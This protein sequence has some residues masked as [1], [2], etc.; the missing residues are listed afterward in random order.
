MASKK[1]KASTKASQQ[2]GSRRGTS[3]L[4]AVWSRRILAVGLGLGVL[5]VPSV[6]VFGLR[7][8]FGPPKALVL[9][10]GA[11]LALA[12]LALDTDATAS[13][14]S[15]LRRSR[16]AWAAAALVGIAV[17]STAT[18]LD[19]RLAFIGGYPDYRGLLSV[20]AYAALALGSI[21]FWERPKGP[22][23][24]GRYAVV[25]AAWVGVIAVLQRA[26]AFPA[27]RPGAF[28]VQWRVSSTLGNSSNLGVFLV[29]IAP[30]L[31]WVALKDPR[32][33]WRAA[34]SA[35]ATLAVISLAWTLSR[36]AW[37]GAIVSA[38]LCGALVVWQRGRFSPRQIGV[39]LVGLAVV[40]AL[41]VALTPTFASRAATLFDTRSTTASW[42][43]STWRS[44]ARMTAARPFLGFGPNTFRLAYPGFQSPGQIDG[45][46]G[47]QIVEAAHNL[48]FDTSTSFGVA[49]LLALLAVMGLACATVF[50]EVRRDGI[51]DGLTASIGIALAGGVV[52]LQ[53]HYLT[54]DT[55]PLVAV[56]LAGLVVADSR[57]TADESSLSSSAALAG[58]IAAGVL[59]GLYLV[60]AGLSAGL[61]AAD[62]NA[63]LAEQ[64]A[65]RGAAWNSVDGPLSRAEALAFWEPQIQRSR[66]TAA[67]TILIKRFDGPAAVSGIRALDAVARAT[68]EDAI[69]AAERA[70]L[71]LAAG[72]AGKDRALLGRAVE[73]FAIVERMDPNTGV[74][75]AGRATALLALGRT[76]EAITA[77]ERA[78]ELSPRYK[79]AWRNLAR[80][81]RIAGR[82]AD[83]E[84][85]RLR[86]K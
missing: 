14:G 46:N 56:L 72:L 28:G 70:N 7:N 24:M 38:L 57:Q 19:V 44:A 43:L 32:R 23:L 22:E 11:A 2:V 80:A 78:V 6:F 67:T 18:A 63:A 41:G 25:A 77:F 3:D 73:A 34:A 30:L 84:K 69:V 85:A 35:S 16:L 21:V 64:L 10:L 76:S 45:R 20:I 82:T 65:R 42:R 5:G 27:G 58:R 86:G 37:L 66:G 83:A 47:Y 59:A 13:I 39:A 79:I 9:A 17:L 15:T 62:R 53:F 1:P 60:A 75:I 71:L 81:Y 48:E 68:P 52:A 74:P 36:G 51:G 29:L 8:P 40:L 61:V 49:G 12:G 50:R 55:A 54:M 4:R 26:G 31:V 33:S